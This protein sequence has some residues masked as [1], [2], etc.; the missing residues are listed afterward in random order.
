VL[1]AEPTGQ[2]AKLAETATKPSLAL[3]QKR[4]LGGT[5]CQYSVVDSL[6]DRL[7]DCDMKVVFVFFS[8]LIPEMMA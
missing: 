2:R 4:S 6:L 5:T 1:E 3:L 8:R 7:T